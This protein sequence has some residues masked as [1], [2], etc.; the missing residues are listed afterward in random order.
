MPSWSPITRR[1]SRTLFGSFGLQRSR[2]FCKRL[3]THTQPTTLKPSH[4]NVLRTTSSS[5]E[6]APSWRMINERL[7][8]LPDFERSRLS[9][10][11][12]FLSLRIRREH[13]PLLRGTEMKMVDA[14][15]GAW[16]VVEIADLEKDGKW[17]Y[18]FGEHP[19][20]QFVYDATGHLHIQ[21]MK[22]PA[23]AP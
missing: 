4:L 9:I 21:I 6:W 15:I 17:R 2:R 22:D 5:M 19:R 14:M 13:A 20:G 10:A 23:L 3:L 12:G 16:R 8:F 11:A 18:R 7:L 1:S